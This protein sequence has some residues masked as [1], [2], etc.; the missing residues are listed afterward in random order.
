MRLSASGTI[1]LVLLACSL[2]SL[3][4]DL[5]ELKVLYVGDTNAARAEQFRGFLSNKVA[6]VELASR[7]GFDYSQ[8]K[9]F[10]VVL[11]DWPQSGGQ[12]FPPRKSP[13]GPREDWVTPMVLLGSAGLHMAIVWDVKGGSG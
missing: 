11:L 5:R 12:N 4:T 1:C 7:E 2:T 9:R 6:R 10:D 3:G 13:L 8:A